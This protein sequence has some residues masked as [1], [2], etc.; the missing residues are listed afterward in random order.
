MVDDR[1]AVA[2]DIVAERVA[3]HLADPELLGDLWGD[4]YPEIGEHDWDRICERVRGLIPAGPSADA[5]AA[6]Y[7]YLESRAES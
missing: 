1:L 4:E 7:E 5:Y 3:A 6:A 2:L